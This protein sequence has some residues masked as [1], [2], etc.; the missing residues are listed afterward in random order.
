MLEI[1]QKGGHL[2]KAA[3]PEE[4]GLDSRELQAFFAELREKNIENHSFMVLRHGKIA[5]SAWREPYG[6]ELPH[7][8]YSVSKSIT[9]T[10]IGFA[11]AEGLLTTATRVVDIFPAYRPQTPDAF[12]EKL[13][14]HHLL[15]MTSGKNVSLLSDKSAGNWVKQFFDA[16]WEYEPG[17]D[18]SYINEN[19][20][21]LCAIL[22]K[23]TGS[24]VRDFLRPRLFEPLGILRHP[25]WETDE[26]GVEAGGWGLFLT[27]E[28]LAKITLCY[29]QNGQWEGKQVIP[30]DWV[31]LATRSHVDNSARNN[32]RDKKMGY[33]YCFWQNVQPNSYRMDGMFSQFGIVLP[34]YDAVIITTNS[35]IDEQKVLDCIW[36]HFP[37]AFGAERIVPQAPAITLEPLPTLPAA[38]RSSLEKQIEGREIHFAKKRG[39]NALHNPMSMLSMGIVYMS[40]NKAGNIDKLSLRFAADS[41]QLRWTE[42]AETNTVSCGMDG[43]ARRT[44]IRLAEINFTAEASAAWADEHT[45][46][47]RVRPLES[48]VERRIR[49][50]FK[51]EKVTL[52]PS[53][54]PSVQS[55]FHFLSTD[56]SAFFP[57]RVIAK[58]VQWGMRH[59]TGLLEPAHHGK[60]CR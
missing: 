11:V 57:N 24:S 55:C 49:L 5:F 48:I 21:M 19:I 26:N 59:L 10:A 25:F 13:T 30:A 46:E 22:H 35:E 9:S 38:V 41:C 20:Y 16:K 53:S 36:N 33:G 1:Q 23:V 2:P 45:L 31:A 18:W 32:S 3:C 44:P 54:M 17:T 58:M 37:A 29:L 7:T 28:E 56:I 15:S 6:P 27:T 14:V 43:T 52:L 12:L 40:A 34:D 8:M 50:Q 4:L 60:F 47:I 39:L 42:G 51:G